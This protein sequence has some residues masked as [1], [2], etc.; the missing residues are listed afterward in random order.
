MGGGSQRVIGSV[1][2]VQLTSGATLTLSPR[3]GA[4]PVADRLKTRS[5]AMSL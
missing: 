4:A 5:V 2:Y 3:Q 1:R